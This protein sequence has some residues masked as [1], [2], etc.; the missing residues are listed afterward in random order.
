M[1]SESKM[2]KQHLLI[3]LVGCASSP[4]FAQASDPNSEAA[5]RK[6]QAEAEE[7]SFKA[8]KAAAEAKEAAAKAELA[9]A[10]KQFGGVTGQSGI[11]GA[12]MIGS[13]A[14]K[15]EAMLLVTRSLETAAMSAAAD[16]TQQLK[17]CGD[18]LKPPPCRLLV[19]SSTTD[20]AAA[21][22][23]QFDLQVKQ[24]DVF[25]NSARNLYNYAKIADKKLDTTQLND[26]GNDNARSAFAIGGSVIDSLSKLGSYFTTDYTFGEVAPNLPVT[27]TSSLMI[28]KI[29]KSH[30]NKSLIIVVPQNLL[31]FDANEII[32]MLSP[33]STQYSE[34]LGEAANAKARAAELKLADV[35]KCPKCSDIAGLYLVA[36]ASLMKANT[37]FEAVLNSLSA[38]PAAGQQP[39][40]ARIIRQNVVRNELRN[41]PM[42][43]LLE[44]QTAAA[45]YTKKNLWTFLGGPP[46][47]TMG[48][49]VLTYTLMKHSGEILQSGAAKEHGG[50]K[51]LKNVE[52]LFFRNSNGK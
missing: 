5:T 22:A 24:S 9:A 32:A 48:G 52:R 7:A 47:H 38:A 11:P 35:K 1:T 17:N 45:Y 37:S 12:T 18:G 44:A 6:A 14:L 25:F 49:T 43:L 36:E 27:L 28:S 3:A 16:L 26:D 39:Y 33:L 13:G 10:Q 23:I 46:V 2:K 20:L 15:G 8:V 29:R 19:L 40:A 21:D 50:Y 41:E 34:A 4:L 30:D 31:A 42:I 51:S